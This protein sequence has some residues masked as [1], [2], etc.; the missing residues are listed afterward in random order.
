MKNSFQLKNPLVEQIL[1]ERYVQKHGEKLNEDII[2]D[3]SSFYSFI[4]NPIQMLIR[5]FLSGNPEE[6]VKFAKANTELVNPEQ[7]KLQAP[8]VRYSTPPGMQLS[9]ASTIA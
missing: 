1:R 2:S 4:T 6:A 5:T 8:R 7:L 3:A 9:R